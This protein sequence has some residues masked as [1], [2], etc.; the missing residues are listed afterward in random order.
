MFFLASKGTDL[1]SDIWPSRKTLE[2]FL[3]E[4]IYDVRFVYHE[5]NPLIMTV[6]DNVAFFQKLFKAILERKMLEDITFTEVLWL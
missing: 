5:R 1:P 4:Y 6:V 2:N 3:A